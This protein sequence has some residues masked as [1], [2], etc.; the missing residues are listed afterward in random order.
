[1]RTPVFGSQRTGTASGHSARRSRRSPSGVPCGGFLRRAGV[2]RDSGIT[3]W[4]AMLLTIVALAT[5]MALAEV[6]SSVNIAAYRHLQRAQALQ[7]ATA[8]LERS[9]LCLSFTNI[10]TDHA[11]ISC[12]GDVGAASY[13]LDINWVSDNNVSIV[14]T[15]TSGLPRCVLSRGGA[16]S[17]DDTKLRIVNYAGDCEI[18]FEN[19]VPR[20]DTRDPL[21]SRGLPEIPDFNYFKQLAIAQGHYYTGNKRFQNQNIPNGVHFAEGNMVLAGGHCRL[22]SGILVCMGNFTLS[23]DSDLFSPS[24]QDPII[25]CGGNVT[26][27]NG[28][29]RGAVYANGSYYQSNGHV[30][31]RVSAESFEHSNGTLSDGGIPAVYSFLNGFTYNPLG[32]GYLVTYTGW[33]EQN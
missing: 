2:R 30:V 10:L 6:A 20:M 4:V 28:D 24:W 13:T 23:N 14:S 16:V 17:P 8:G 3:L 25:V 15:G 18:K 33:S 26:I 12:S 11:P 1:M 19:K 9:R 5:S 21:K 27:S 22:A 29:V 31:G 32:A 7:A